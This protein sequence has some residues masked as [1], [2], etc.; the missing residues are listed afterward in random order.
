[1]AFHHDLL[2]QAEHLAAREPKRPKQASLRRAVSAA[3]YALFHLLVADGARFLSPTQPRGLTLRIRRAFNHGDMRNV[4]KGFVKA[5][6]AAGRGRLSDGVPDATRV[7]LTFP[8]EPDL[9]KVLEAFVDLQEARHQADYD[10][11]KTW[12]RL[13]AE[14]HVAAA[15]NAF[16]SWQ[17][18]RRNSNTSVFVAALLMQRQ[19]GR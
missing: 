11:T 5:N 6:V 16:A 4:C 18:I 9:V 8:L 7:L 17:A 10:P 15:R 3:Y 1:L 13:G 2:E 19:W 12:N 14:T